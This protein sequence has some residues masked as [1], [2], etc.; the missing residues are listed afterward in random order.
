MDNTI[1][2]QGIVIKSS[3]FKENSKILTVFTQELGKVSIMAQ[4][5]MKPNS[6]ALVYSEAFST[7]EFILKKGRNFYYIIS[8]DLIDSHY[9][10]RESIDVMAVGF[11]F[12][13]LVDKSIP[14]A[15]KNEKIYKMI[16]VALENLGNNIINRL[17][18]VLGYELKLISLIGY[19][20]YLLNCIDC[21]T[22]NSIHW[23]F[24]NE[25]G[26]ILCS[27]CKTRDSQ[28]IDSLYIR[29]MINYISL[30]FNKLSNDIMNYDDKL[31]LN[32]LIYKYILDKL[33]IKELKS[34]NMLKDVFENSIT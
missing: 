5:A 4:G 6:K 31:K 7:S 17:D 26:G 20:P 9:Y 33:D 22:S 28:Y 25:K 8:V 11:Y 12:L 24:D 21:H 14:E 23:Y 30:P 3:K 27:N 2:T 32:V 19:K 34:W 10:L 29:Q 1:K 15:E 16:I 18:L 13:D